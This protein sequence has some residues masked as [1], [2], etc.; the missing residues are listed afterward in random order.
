MNRKIEEL[1]I[2]KG[3]DLFTRVE[4]RRDFGALLR[5]DA[6]LEANDLRVYSY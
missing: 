3:E 1:S 4:T 6:E 2:E 5:V